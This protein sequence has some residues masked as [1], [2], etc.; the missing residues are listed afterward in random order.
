MEI[1]GNIGE[2]VYIKAKI[3][4]ITI[5]EEEGIVYMVTAHDDDDLVPIPENEIRFL[6]SKAAEKKPA[7]SNEEEKGA[8]EHSAWLDEL[9]KQ[10]GFTKAKFCDE[11]NAWI[12][13]EKS[14][15]K[16]IHIGHFYPA[17][18]TNYIKGRKNM[19]GYKIEMIDMFQKEFF[20]NREE[21]DPISTGRAKRATV[22]STMAKLRKMRGES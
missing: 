13:H 15:G 17:D 8:F 22:E 21:P 1:K 6:P 9:I 12:D 20:T 4:G 19:S 11:V 7:Q 16:E 10:S 2:E 18:L 3:R 5:S 14:L